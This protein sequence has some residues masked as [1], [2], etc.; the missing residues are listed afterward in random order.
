M[1]QTAPLPKSQNL[2]LSA[3]AR[4][5][6]RRTHDGFPVSLTSGAAEYD[7]AGIGNALG[8]ILPS[9]LLPRKLVGR[10]LRRRLLLVGYGA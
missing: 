2:D 5:C 10:Y 4:P 3:N 6:L 1:Q 7:Q 9:A 8:S